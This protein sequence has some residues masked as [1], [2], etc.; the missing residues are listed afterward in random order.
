MR[1]ACRPHK[2]GCHGCG[3]PFPLNKNGTV[4]KN[5]AWCSSKCERE[6]IKD[7]VWGEARHAVK[8][9]DEFKCVIC[10]QDDKNETA[11]LYQ[12]RYGKSILEVNHILPV[13]GK[14]LTVSCANHQDN[15]ETL[16]HPCHVDVTKQ[17][18]AAGL[19]VNTVRHLI[20]ILRLPAG[21]TIFCTR[22]GVTVEK[23][24]WARKRRE[25]CPA[26]TKKSQRK[27]LRPKRK[28]R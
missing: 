19:L 3:A 22:C 27:A 10:G 14:R 9:R 25:E 13:N 11:R 24:D 23:G 8:V 17:Q 5:R 26:G 12:R 15:L 20:Q 21:V 16:C 18:R 2:T 4:P 7:H 6:V 28:R 1:V